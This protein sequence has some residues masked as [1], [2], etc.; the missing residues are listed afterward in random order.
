MKVSINR[1]LVASCYVLLVIALVLYSSS[2][3]NSKRLVKRDTSDGTYDLST[4]AR[5]RTLGAGGL[6]SS[7]GASIRGYLTVKQSIADSNGSIS[8][9]TIQPVA[10]PIIIF[11]G[12]IVV[13]ALLYIVYNVTMWIR[14]CVPGGCCKCCHRCLF[15]GPRNRR[16]AFNN[17]F[18]AFIVFMVFAFTGV[19]MAAAILAA[20]SASMF[21]TGVSEASNSITAMNASINGMLGEIPDLVGNAFTDGLALINVSLVVGYGYLNVTG[22][23][24]NLTVPVNSILT[25]LRDADDNIYLISEYVNN[26]VSLIDNLTSIQ[27]TLSNDVSN[28]NVNLDNYQNA[29]HVSSTNSTLTFS[30]NGSKKFTTSDNTGAADLSSLKSRL[31]DLQTKITPPTTPN[32]TSIAQTFEDQFNDIPNMVET[33]FNESTASATSSFSSNIDSVK[34]SVLDSLPIYSM[35]DTVGSASS[36]AQDYLVEYV[37]KYLVYYKAAVITL[38]SLIA[39]LVFVMFVGAGY[40]NPTAIKWGLY[41]F[42]FLT[43]LV[44][45]ISAVFLVVSFAGGMVCEATSSPSNMNTYLSTFGSLINEQI[46]PDAVAKGFAARGNCSNGASILDIVSDI[47][48]INGT[49]VDFVAQVKEQIDNANLDSIANG[50]NISS[51]LGFGGNTTEQIQSIL[52]LN[53]TTLN[54]ANETSL[55]GNN[56]VKLLM[57]A[58]ISG[59]TSWKDGLTVN[60]FTYSN[61]SSPIDAADFNNFTNAISNFIASFQSYEDSYNAAFDEL[62]PLM[63]GNLTLI[64][65]TSQI[66]GADAE[67]ISSLYEEIINSVNETSTAFIGAINTLVVPKTTDYLLSGVALIEASVKEETDCVGIA[68]ASYQAQNGLC[69]YIQGGIDTVWF[70]SYLIG[71][72]GFL[73]TWIFFQA[74]H[75]FNRKLLGGGY[76][77]F[78]G[79]CRVAPDYKCQDTI[80]YSANNGDGSGVEYN[81]ENKPGSYY[82]NYGYD[83][84]QTGV[85][86]DNAKKGGQ[87]EN[88]G[89]AANDILPYGANNIVK[90]NLY[91]DDYSSEPYEVDRNVPMS[92]NHDP[93]A[94]YLSAGNANYYAYANQPMNGNQPQI[95]GTSHYVDEKEHPET[96]SLMAPEFDAWGNSLPNSHGFVKPESSSYRYSAQPPYEPSG[97]YQV[98]EDKPVAQLSGDKIVEDALGDQYGFISKDVQQ[99][100]TYSQPDNANFQIPANEA[101]SGNFRQSYLSSDDNNRASQSQR[102]SAMIHA[103]QVP[104]LPLE[105]VSEAETNN[106][107]EDQSNS[108]Q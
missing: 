72:F 54:L 79:K 16:L 63:S 73:C 27:T 68:A 61:G 13:F 69:M 24:A 21:T 46:S 98:Q 7:F 82:P 10:L 17:K 52:N 37:V 85:T 80:S 59:L 11:A 12:I 76:F 55:V 8:W 62:S 50:F 53:L 83:D 81:P 71:I 56:T 19:Y 87:E 40:G 45:I 30:I 36:K 25:K 9:A 97:H 57:D 106:Q 33:K 66:L 99:T 60:N 75:K 78:G 101:N 42:L 84:E 89:Y 92:D 102:D 39:L 107:E 28:E 51:V 74:G 3:T 104:S 105:A 91:Q 103:D 31:Q 38:F 77:G 6:W 94:S 22:L 34:T 48:V 4:S 43:I 70:S 95:I 15:F 18:K 88:N 67:S 32:L 58:Y 108:Q 41:P 5:V 1:L 44:C 2:T 93:R 23:M 90:S 20:L 64:Q 35:Q 86:S 96:T 49:M 14:C 65:N 26:T 100:L 29:S 47:G